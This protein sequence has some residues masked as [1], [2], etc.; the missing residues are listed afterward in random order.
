MTSD[1]SS[2]TE[3]GEIVARP[4]L[5]YRVKRYLIVVMLLAMAGWFAYD[6]WVGYPKKN[7]E[8]L[9]ANPGSKPP[10]SD[11]SIFLQK[12]LAITLPV[13]AAGVLAWTLY[14]SRGVY[15]LRE[16]TLHVPG[17]PP[18]PLDAIRAIDQSKWDRKGIA[19]IDY[20]VQGKRGR[21]KLD[22]YMYQREPTDQIHDRIL[23]TVA[24]AEAEGSSTAP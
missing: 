12:M 15:R 10:E 17:H 24:P 18:V 14:N 2:T 5:E 6:G 7:R 8:A 4:S 19:Y 20:E 13:A 16:K 9:I 3:S 1:A 11:L 21:L 23:A 22:D